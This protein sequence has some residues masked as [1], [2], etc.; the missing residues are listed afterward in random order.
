MT[1]SNTQID[2]QIESLKAKKH[3]NAI[4]GNIKKKC[5]D[6]L[7]FTHEAH[8]KK[9]VH[10]AY[11]AN[12]DELYGNYALLCREDKWF[13]FS[14]DGAHLDIVELLDKKAYHNWMDWDET[15]VNLCSEC[16]KYLSLNKVVAENAKALRLEGDRI[17]KAARTKKEKL[18]K[19]ANRLDLTTSK[20]DYEGTE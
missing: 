12:G 6:T 20:G 13:S 7:F 16:K 5:Y 15:L 1:L 2:R 3:D 11:L 8:Y 14:D 4:R 9:R 18:Y 10:F 19:Q 17:L